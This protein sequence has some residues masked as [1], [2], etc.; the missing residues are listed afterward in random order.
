MKLQSGWVGDICETKRVGMEGREGRE[1][2]GWVLWLGHSSAG[3]SNGNRLG[4]E[5]RPNWDRV[6]GD[7][8][9]CRT[10]DTMQMWQDQYYR[11][12]ENLN[13][14]I[15][16]WSG[17]EIYQSIDVRRLIWLFC[18]LYQN[19]WQ[20]VKISAARN[21]ILDRSFSLDTTRWSLQWAVELKHHCGSLLI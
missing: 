17:Q 6:D 3:S 14:D 12:E 10:Q 18:K 15:I 7:W 5:E 1:F 11:Y 19:S 4:G 8:Q 13:I 16:Y 9:I 20:G 21:W 2:L